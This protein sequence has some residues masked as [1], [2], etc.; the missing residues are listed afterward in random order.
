MPVP[1]P[2]TAS[3]TPVLEARAVTKR[4][5]LHGP[6]QH[7]KE[8]HALEETSLALHEGRI[9]ALVGES[10][11]GKSTLARLLALAHPPTD[12]EIRLD[13]AAVQQA[14]TAR[15]RRAYHR[16]VQMVFQD[17][18]SSLSPVHRVRYILGRPLQLHGHASGRAQLDAQIAQLLERVNLTPADQYIDKFPHE[19]SGGQRQR[20]AIARALAARPKVL[21]GDEPVSMLDVSIRLDIL[22]LL[23]R[24]R[25]DEG[26][27][28]LYI[29][30]DIASARYFADEIK[31]LYA[32]QLV[33][34]GPGDAVVERPLH[35]YTRLLLESAPDP[36][37][38]GLLDEPDVVDDAETL[39]EPPSLVDPP[40]GCRF[41]P[42]CPL[43]RPVCATAFPART[44]VE[45]GQWVHCW[46]YDEEHYA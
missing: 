15:G 35:P 3:A 43:A 4:F 38:G 25:D 44:H 31:V 29:T 12:G 21:L 20:V 42:R 2:R 18:F 11:S 34:S 7:G 1:E 46:S 40:T 45:G 22:N 23:N 10:G 8:V 32:G 17:P 9:T 28:I 16:Q 39:G 36:D 30:H 26:L 13:G 24:L 33:E 6:G 5:P 41:H 27:A 37:R 14:R 19:L